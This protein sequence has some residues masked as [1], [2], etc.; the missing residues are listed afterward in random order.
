M[1]TPV[2]RCERIVAALEDLAAQEAAGVAQNDFAAV[3]ALHERTAPLV[4]YL[5]AAGSELLGAPGLR[6]RLIAVYELRHR[7][8]EALAAAMARVRLEMAQAEATQ[9]RVA[10]IMPVYGQHAVRTPQLQ[11]V[12]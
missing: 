12:G 9:R 8:G 11:V 3:Q 6:R 1:E 5:A 4:E 2:Q 7:S 10:R